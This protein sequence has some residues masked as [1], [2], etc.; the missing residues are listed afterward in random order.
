MRIN[1][2]YKIDIEVQEGGKKKDKLSVFLREFT[3]AEK[4]EHEE[5][6]KKFE[7]IFTKVQ[8]IGKKQTVLQK[9]AELYELN[10]DYKSA[11]ETVSKI[12]KLDAEIEVL[13]EELD[14]IGGGNQ[15]EF[16]ENS[17]KDR[18]DALVSGKDKEKLKEL[19][20]IKGYST[21]MRELDIAKSELEKKQYGE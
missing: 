14:E 2:D 17:A 9:K 19:A 20:E 15:D 7:R 5:L 11:I 3:K 10:E 16:A 18:F 8:K 13:I 4:K 12:E 6:R 1:L 21:I